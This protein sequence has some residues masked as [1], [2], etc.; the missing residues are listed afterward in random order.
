MGTK[1][2]EEISVKILKK[3][4]LRFIGDMDKVHVY[5]FDKFLMFSEGR[6]EKMLRFVAE[7]IF[8]GNSKTFLAEILKKS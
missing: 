1:V 2:F 4:L 8:K 5:I 6:Q 3:K 7:V